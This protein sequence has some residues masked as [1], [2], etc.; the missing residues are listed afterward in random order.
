MHLPAYAIHRRPAVLLGP[1]GHLRRR[2]G[3]VGAA[4]A[5]RARLIHERLRIVLQRGRLILGP[6]R[7]I[8]AAG[9][10][11]SGRAERG[12]GRDDRHHGRGHV[13]VR[14]VGHHCLLL[15]H[16]G[17]HD[18]HSRRLRL[19][20]LRQGRRPDGTGT[21][22]VG[23][24]HHKRDRR[25]PP[26]GGGP[27][28]LRCPRNYVRSRRAD[29]AARGSHAVAGHVHAEADLRADGGAQ[30]SRGV[31]GGLPKVIHTLDELGAC[32]VLPGRL[33]TASKHV[34]PTPSSGAPQ[35]A[36]RSSNILPVQDP[37]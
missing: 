27:R 11:R 21:G 5:G 8:A 3:T 29:V 4:T 23:E 6:L 30:T 15:D 16:H 14:R 7:A 9:N 37:P 28:N 17:L 2:T 18:L 20:T 24:R 26:S 32:E 34:H 35:I 31:R 36:W 22:R 13:P 12:T 25:I 33:L 19:H 10:E 1:S